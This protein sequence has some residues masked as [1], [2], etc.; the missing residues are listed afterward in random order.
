MLISPLDSHATVFTYHGCISY[1]YVQRPIIIY[2][3]PM[4]LRNTGYVTDVCRWDNYALPV[5]Q[6]KKLPHTIFGE[7]PSDAEIKDRRHQSLHT[8]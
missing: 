2:G 5:R 3:E 1:L 8:T 6:Q 4:L 7:I